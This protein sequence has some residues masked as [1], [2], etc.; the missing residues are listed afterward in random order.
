[1]FYDFISD[2]DDCVGII[3]QH[4]GTCRDGINTFTCD[5][6]AGYEGPTCE[7]SK[8]WSR[9]E[10]FILPFRDFRAIETSWQQ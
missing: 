6:V 5:C 4:G 2:I 9:D 3:C 8:W 1:M 7:M 10:T